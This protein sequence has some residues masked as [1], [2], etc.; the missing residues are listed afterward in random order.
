MREGR[1][2]WRQALTIVQPATLPPTFLDQ[3]QGL[4][5][6][7]LATLAAAPDHSLREA[8]EHFGRSPTPEEMVVTIL[9]S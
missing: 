7:A 9:Q 6:A 8:R 5:L 3:R 4:S 2:A 1:A